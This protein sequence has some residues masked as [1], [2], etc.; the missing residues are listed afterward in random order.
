VLLL[1]TLNGQRTKRD[2]PAVPLTPE[3]L[4]A[5]AA[6]CERAGARA[7]HIHPRDE[8]GRECL[9]AWI[10]DESVAAVRNVTRWPVGV[11]TGA[12][13]EP[14]TRRRV[15]RVRAW[16]EPDCASVNV[17]EEGAF[18]VMR[19]LLGSGIGVEAGVSTAEDAKALVCSGLEQHLTR[20]L[21]EP[22]AASA[23]EALRVVA[24]IHRVLDRAHLDVPRLQHGEGE[25]AWLLLEDAVR[26]GVDTRIGLEDTML[27]PDGALAAD[28][29][30]LVGAARALGAGCGEADD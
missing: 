22:V 24:A 4:C 16:H 3:E 14:E 12:W 5:D 29:A 18:D 2:H 10:V 23:V 6:A 15:Q 17:S 11:T 7:F 30:A 21:V 20:V 8:S 9:D 27:L 26:R 1:A 19:A 25:G 13:I 28:N